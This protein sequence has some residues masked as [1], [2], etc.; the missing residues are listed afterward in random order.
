M[1]A[2]PAGR[3]GAPLRSVRIGSLSSGPATSDPYFAYLAYAGHEP[4]AAVTFEYT[5]AGLCG[6]LDRYRLSGEN[7]F[8]KT[9]ILRSRWYHVF[10]WLTG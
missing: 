7:G 3:A 5:W 4:P 9:P 2:L 6:V 8:V 10:H 1:P